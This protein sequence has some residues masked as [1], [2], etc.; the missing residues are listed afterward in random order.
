MSSPSDGADVAMSSKYKLP[1]GA[2]ARTLVFCFCFFVCLFVCLFSVE[3][4]NVEV[5]IFSD[6]AGRNK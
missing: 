2:V 1:T 6:L 3:I 4:G 5:K